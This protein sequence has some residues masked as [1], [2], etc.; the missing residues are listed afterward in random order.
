M[1]L[2]STGAKP[3]PALDED[4]FQQLLAAAYVVQQH[5]EAP[6]QSE[7]LSGTSKVLEIIAEIQAH[8]RTQNLNISQSSALIAERI[9]ALTGASGVSISLVD[10]G[11]LDCVAEAGVPASI[12]GSSI[13]S[14]SL[15]AT[16]RLKSGQMFESGKAET[17]LRIDGDLCR[18]I[19]VGSLVGAP[20]L[21]FGEIA[22]LL[23]VRWSTPEAFR[24]A[25]LR[26]CRLI[27]GLVTGT[28]E[29]SV[30]LGKAVPPQS[31]ITPAPVL[32]K[33][34]VPE[35]QSEP[36]LIAAELR[37]AAPADENP[38]QIP[39]EARAEEQVANETLAASCRM[40]GR[41]FA[42]NELFCGFCSMPRPV[43]R[44]SEELQSKWAS[45]WF[46]QRAKG[47]IEE[48]QAQEVEA[49]DATQEVPHTPAPDFEINA[50]VASAEPVRQ[51]WPRRA[52]PET[53]PEHQL[54][55]VQESLTSDAYATDTRF[56]F[57][58]KPPLS[59]RTAK[60][61]RLH[62]RDLVLTSIVLA[63]GYAAFTAW[64]RSPDR[65]TWFQSL[66]V[67][68]GVMR[69][70][71]K[72]FLGAPDKRVWIDVHTEL[73]YCSGEDLYGKTPDG[74]FTTQY[75]AQ[76]DGYQPASTT[77]CP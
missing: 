1:T 46:M 59:E 51:M 32:P 49:E 13:C 30:R 38:A 8:I 5:R 43:E 48:A 21:R 72:V 64:P 2:S 22:G 53:G 70:P 41:A 40:C 12:P 26:T 75:N 77:T 65:P 47:A 18:K 19:G 24:E 76:S 16:E 73:Y 42:G 15:V 57:D 58:E 56:P 55:L 39:S 34:S 7:A 20:V 63:L 29:R 28:L 37:A 9:L 45:L 3:K 71:A 23:E 66:M 74:E 35:V 25:E 33:T 69:P 50:E 44:R 4:S 62:W 6:Q 67:R 27:A 52:P 31:E 68:A 14:H 54:P 17:D 60:F 10:N 61:A 11:Y 36:E